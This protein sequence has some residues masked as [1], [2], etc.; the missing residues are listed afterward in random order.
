[1]SNHSASQGFAAGCWIYSILFS[2]YWLKYFEEEECWVCVIELSIIKCEGKS[3]NVCL[4][5]TV[6]G[7]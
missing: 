4:I 5:V 2:E 7:E 3:S 6:F 1:M